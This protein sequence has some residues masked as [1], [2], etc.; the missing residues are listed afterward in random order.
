MQIFNKLL[1]K[2]DFKAFL[3]LTR[4]EKVVWIK[5]YTNQQN[6]V[7]I[8]EFLDNPHK[9]V[10]GCCIGCGNNHKKNESI[11]KANAIEVADSGT[12]IVVAEPSTADSVERPKNA[13]RGKNK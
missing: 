6:D 8:N 5:K 2:D 7:L 11:S 4:E 12:E 9:E 1:G 3:D 10:D 13:K